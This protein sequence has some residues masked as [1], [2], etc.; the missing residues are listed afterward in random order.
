MKRLVL[1][2]FKREG[3]QGSYAHYFSYKDDSL[4]VCLE[5]CLSGYDIAIYDLKQNLLVPKECTNIDMSLGE[6]APGFSMLTSD[7][8]EK[9]IKIANKLYN[10]ELRKDKNND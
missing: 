1:G 6:I 9:A 4:E 10:K 7:A 8:I 3:Q 5:A 2:S